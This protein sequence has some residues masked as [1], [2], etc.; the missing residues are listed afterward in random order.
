MST[1]GKDVAVQEQPQGSTAVA[2]FDYSADAGVGFE[3]VKPGDFKPSFIRL[4][5]SNSPQVVD[6]MPG[7]KIGAYADSLT[8]EF[9]P[10]VTFV[11]AVREH[12]IVAW[13]PR[14]EG[15]GGGQGFGG[16]FQLDDPEIVKQLATVPD[17]FAKGEDGKIILPRSKDGEYQLIETVYYHGVQVLPNGALVP[18]TIPFSS[19]GLKC[20]GI[21]L[22]LAG[23]QV[24]T[25]GPAA[26]KQYPL[27]AHAYKLTSQK[28]EADGNKWS[29][30]LV[31]WAKG[32]A[33]ESRLDPKGSI[34]AVARGI[35]DAFKTGKAKVDYAAAGQGAGSEGHSG[36]GKSAAGSKDEEIP[37]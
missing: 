9:Y 33:D 26:G 20:A 27:F 14:N 11:P 30:P 3:N 31:S 7:A 22:T 1:T 18:A 16:V 24:I 25:E 15:G 34:I 19:T 32:S 23:R 8:N 2:A 17:K 12:V 6:E 4:L 28:R 13:K 10:E 36:G 29:V 5:Q 21:W 35:V 37:F